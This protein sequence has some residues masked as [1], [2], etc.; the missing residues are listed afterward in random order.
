MSLLTARVFTKHTMSQDNPT[1]ESVINFSDIKLNTALA[2]TLRS[3]P[4]GKDYD[5][6]I[7]NSCNVPFR[8]VTVDSNSD[9]LLCYC[10][11]WLPVSVGQVTDF[12]T[13]Q[14]IWTS[15]IAKML[16]NDIQQKKFTWCAVQ[17]CGVINHDVNREHYSLNINIDDSCNLACPSC[18]RET[19]M[20]SQGSEYDKKILHV[21]RILTWLDKF[22]HPIRVSFGGN[23]DALASHI[24][25]NLIKNYRYKFGQT[26]QI[27]TN[28]LLL[29]KVIEDSTIRP[30]IDVFSVSVDAGTQKVYENVRRPGKWSTLLE[31]LEWLSC[32]RKNSYV[33]LNFVVQ[34][35]NFRDL[36]AFVDLCARFQFNGTVTPLNDWGTWNSQPVA[37]PDAWTLAN[38]TYLEHDV[39]NPEHPEHTDFVTTLHS[40]RERNLNF[41]S[42][43]PFFEKFL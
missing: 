11:G 16:Q 17:H 9:C 34:K 21:D 31:N 7:N 12:D 2:Y 29:K 14:D 33:Q 22:E 37:N 23:G 6:P 35:N 5:Q 40:V 27:T 26:F 28:G 13:L 43:N 1:V 4:R 8:H 25:R 36:P 30:A 32:N 18:R 38:G 42:F 24:F 20:L 39:T 19:R 10:D 3:M 41:I 15:P